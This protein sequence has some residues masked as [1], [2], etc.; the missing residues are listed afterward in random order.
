MSG[1]DKTVSVKSFVYYFIG[2]VNNDKAFEVSLD[3][4]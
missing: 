3:V 4:F 1:F 2:Q